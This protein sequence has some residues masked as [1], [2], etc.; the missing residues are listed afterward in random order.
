MRIQLYPKKHRNAALKASVF[1]TSTPEAGIANLNSVHIT[2]DV[3]DISPTPGPT[4]KIQRVSTSP[5]SQ[6]TNIARYGLSIPCFWQH[7]MNH[8]GVIQF[9]LKQNHYNNAWALLLRLNAYGGKQTVLWQH[10]CTRFPKHITAAILNSRRQRADM[11]PISLLT[12]HKL[13]GARGFVHV[14]RNGAV[15]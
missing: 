1:Y 10:E 4:L 6:A 13:L 3:T 14:L 7:E 15:W 8:Y 2:C 9:S 12:A 11:K 5:T